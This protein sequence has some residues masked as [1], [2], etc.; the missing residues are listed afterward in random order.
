LDDSGSHGE[1]IG[2]KV[3]GK[4]DGTKLRGD[5][6]PGNG[7]VREEE[8]TA[9]ASGGRWNRARICG[10]ESRR[11]TETNRKVGNQSMERVR[12]SNGSRSGRRRGQ[13]ESR[14]DMGDTFQRVVQ[15]KDGG[16][17]SSRASSTVGEV[18]L[19]SHFEMLA[20]KTV[21][22]EAG[23]AVNVAHHTGRSMEDLEEIAKKLLCPTADFV[24]GANVFQN[25]L[26]S[27][28]IAEPEEFRAPKKFPILTDCPSSTGSFA[29][30]GM[31]V[32]FALAAAARAKPNGSQPGA[33]HGQVE[34][35]G[36]VGTEKGKG[37]FGGQ[38]TGRK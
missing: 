11:G 18:E 21:F 36:A 3:K 9:S 5:G 23:K 38:G 25:L 2:M 22:I 35:T 32:A 26:D 17:I 33:V 16:V 19:V 6:K 13:N 37:A 24:D 30:K 15:V 10:R 4:R 29:D 31:K 7:A 28:A 1:Q 27:A 12:S 14:G 8:V 34:I 20:D